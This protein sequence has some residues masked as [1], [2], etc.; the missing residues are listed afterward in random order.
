MRRVRSR[1]E[2]IFRQGDY[3]KAAELYGLMRE[4]L[5]P[6][7]AKRLAFVEGRRVG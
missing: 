3:A 5:S 6:A 2:E 1:L 7:E 4:R